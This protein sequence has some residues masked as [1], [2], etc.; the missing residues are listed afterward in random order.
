MERIKKPHNVPDNSHEWCEHT[1]HFLWQAIAHLQ[2]PVKVAV[3]KPVLNNNNNHMADGEQEGSDLKRLS[4]KRG[5]KM[6]WTCH[7]CIKTLFVR[8]KDSSSQKWNVT[9]CYTFLPTV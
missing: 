5:W 9:F 4:E 8:I 7:T 1:F 2:F 3:S 6:S